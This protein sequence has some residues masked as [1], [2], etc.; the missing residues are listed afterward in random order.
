MAA[1]MPVLLASTG[2]AREIDLE[3]LARRAEVR[4][5]DVPRK[6]L[7]F[8]Y[9]WYG[10]AE[11]PAGSGENA[12]WGRIDV[13]KRDIEASTNY[14][15]LGAYDSHDPK[16]IG[17]HATWSK[18]A[19]LDGWIVSWW[20][21]GS[22]SDRAMP[23][24]L[25]ACGE[26]GLV[27]TVYYETVRGEK[28]PH[29]AARE[30][31]GVLNTYAKHPAW[32]RVE[33]KPVVFVYG[34]AVGELGL[35]GWLAAI[36]EVN[37]TYPGGAVVIGD[38]IS[39]SAARV[40]DGIHTYNTA[41]SLRGL[42]AAG[43]RTWAGETFPRWVALAAREKRIA[44][45]TV[46][47][48]YDDTKIREPGLKVERFAGRSYAAQWEAA[49]AAAPDWVL[50]TSFNEWH[51]GS[52]IEPSAGDGAKY[53]EQTAQWAARF[54]KAPPRAPF[55]E[56]APT[57]PLTEA[58]RESLQRL[59]GA[60]VGVLPGADPDVLW[61][62]LDS[63]MR[64]VMLSP[65]EAAVL[66][67]QSA[68]R[69]PLMLYAG[70]ETYDHTARTPGDVAEGLRRY[71]EGGGLL[72]VFPTGP[73]PMHYDRQGSVVGAAASVGLPLGVGRARGGWEEPP[74]GRTLA[75]VP[76][77]EHLP[78]LPERFGFPRDDP[79]W[80]PLVRND[81]AKADLVIPLIEVRDSRGGRYGAAAAYLEHRHSEPRG[82]KVLYA[83][84]GLRH[85]GLGDGLLGALMA[86]AAE[87]ISPRERQ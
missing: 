17:Q 14:P 29:N 20:G 18:E 40:F 75:M 13:G 44:T 73:M 12:H 28:T 15:Q 71:L 42:D 70:D 7:A 33:G 86:F 22:F 43:V 68:A 79:R 25:A 53:L 38:Q 27:A 45:L 49:I 65:L 48:G 82:G 26:A 32:L 46:I 21:R 77:R 30:I 54:R 16:T 74:E 2:L 63:G 37:R 85:A 24:V 23:R 31:V 39:R 9:P 76:S 19:G 87:R 51:E 81:L 57:A 56:P 5:H 50:I 6:V 3:A 34:R 61:W 59:R 62:L 80:R 1:A 47:P 64:P 78:N 41:G 11:V 4:Y 58:Q 66:D 83:W 8:Y 52:E 60:G 55:A 69:M 36:D 10:N 67:R 72:I 35:T 84:F